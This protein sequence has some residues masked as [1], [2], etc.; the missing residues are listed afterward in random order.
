MHSNH[1]YNLM[2]QL[3]QENKSLWRIKNEYLKDAGDC[4]DCKDFWKKMKIDKE[5]SLKEL[6]ELVKKH[7]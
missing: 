7:F 1:S 5:N 3:V 6:T 2:L 4:D